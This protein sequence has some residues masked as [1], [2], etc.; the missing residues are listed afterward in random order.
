MPEISL[1]IL[2]VAENSVRAGADLIRIIV[3]VKPED[4]TLTVIIADDGCGMT[5]EQ[6][7]QVTDPF[8]TTRTTRKAGLGIP[9]LT[10]AAQ[11][12]GGEV[13]IESEP[14]AGTTTTATFQID[15]IDRKPLGDVADTMTVSIMGHPELE[16][17]LIL[18][19]DESEFVFRTEDVR[20]Q[21]GEVPINDVEI[22]SFIRNM[23]NEQITLLFGG[24]LNEIIS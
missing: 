6:E 14:R 21:I 16:F 19:N 5:E 23:L 24:I 9:L 18:K 4:D 17:H 11:M 3:S 22:I 15:N 8:Y 20:A 13:R 12:A 10:D 7:R 1:N 2:D